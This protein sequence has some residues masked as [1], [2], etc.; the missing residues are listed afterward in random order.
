MGSGSYYYK[1]QT[2]IR[3][4]IARSYGARYGPSLIIAT[5]RNSN[6]LKPTQ[7]ENRKC[8]IIR[9]RYALSIIFLT[10]RNSNQLKMKSRLAELPTP[11]RL[12]G[13][14]SR[15]QSTSTELKSLRNT[16]PAR[17]CASTRQVKKSQTN[18]KKQKLPNCI[19]PLCSCV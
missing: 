19:R 13:L 14:R 12:L 6:Q 18:S 16:A 7:N 4:Q 5:Q 17:V 15:T 3:T 8:Q 11:A 2:R 9:A 1:S 10:Q